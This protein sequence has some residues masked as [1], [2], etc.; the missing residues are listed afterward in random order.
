MNH[1]NPNP[2]AGHDTHEVQYRSSAMEKAIRALGTEDHSLCNR[3][4]AI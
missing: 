2:E 4:V 3:L 1:V